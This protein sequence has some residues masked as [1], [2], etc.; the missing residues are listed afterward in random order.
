MKTLAVPNNR[1]LP[2]VQGWGGR[3]AMRHRRGLERASAYENPASCPRGTLAKLMAKLMAMVYAIGFEDVYPYLLISGQS[4]EGIRAAFMENPSLFILTVLTILGM[5]GPTNTLLATSGA[6]TGWRRS[7][8]LVLAEVGGYLTTIMLLGFVLGPA[9]A[10][11]P[12]V[13]MLLRFAV[14]IYL[15]MLAW[16]LWGWGGDEL[17]AKAISFRQLFVA[18]LFNPKAVIFALAVI[19]FGK[20]HV[21][22]Y[23]LGFAAMV[24]GVGTC[25]L[26]VGEGAGR[27]ARAGGKGQW[28]PR[29]GSAVVS[30]FALLIVVM[31]FFK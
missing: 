5:P 25:W 2:G 1:T 24:V 6:A 29:I 10:G 23:L 26:I 21:A 20:T 3:A 13:K 31:P 30:V 8:L 14:G 27:M 22:A 9:L 19:P 7:W 28:V 17:Q 16:K 4:S 11:A 18:T 15:F 12:V